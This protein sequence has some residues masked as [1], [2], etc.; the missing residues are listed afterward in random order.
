MSEQPEQRIAARQARIRARLERAFRRA[1]KGLY[2]RSL[3][4]EKAEEQY[5]ARGLRIMLHAERL[6]WISHSRPAPPVSIGRD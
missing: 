2:G 1:F 5:K 3:S 6:G 4:I